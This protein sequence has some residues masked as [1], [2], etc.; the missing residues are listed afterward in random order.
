MKSGQKTMFCTKEFAQRENA[1]I[2]K[3]F[4]SVKSLRMDY[5]FSFIPLSPRFRRTGF[6]KR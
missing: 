5:T 2:Q 3:F 6:K 1:W 4:C